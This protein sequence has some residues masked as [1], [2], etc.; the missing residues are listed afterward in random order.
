VIAAA[1][2]FVDASNPQDEMFTINFNEDVWPGLPH[3]L[4]FTSDRDELKRA[5]LRAGTRG[6]TALFDA[7]RTSLEHLQ[8]G[9]R[10][11]KVLIVISDGGDNASTTRFEDVL[12][13]ALRMNAVIYTISIYDEQN[14]EGDKRILKKLA[15]VTGGEAFFP[16]HVTEASSILGRIARDIRSGYTIGYIPAASHDGYRPVRVTVNATDRRKLRVR[17]RSGYVSGKQ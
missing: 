1:T 12:A 11:K 3:G 5:L 13:T 7:L 14:R 6:R 2:S 4:P 17:A 10:Q 16:R 9:Q 15:A 8:S